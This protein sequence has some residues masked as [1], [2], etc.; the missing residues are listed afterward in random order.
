M[1]AAFGVEVL[2]SSRLFIYCK[3]SK[4]FYTDT[5]GTNENSKTLRLKIETRPPITAIALRFQTQRF[6]LKVS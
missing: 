5:S 2:K 1:L 3:G 4:R 6:E